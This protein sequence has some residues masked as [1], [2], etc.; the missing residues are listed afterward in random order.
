MKYLY[1]TLMSGIAATLLL[2]SCSTSDGGSSC[3][4]VS[5]DLEGTWVSGCVSTSSVESR[6][7]QVTFSGDRVTV[8]RTDYSDDVC[9]SMPAFVSPLS[10]TFTTGCAVTTTSGMSAYALDVVADAN[11]F[12]Y[13]DI[14]KIEGDTMY[15]SGNI[16]TASRPQSLDF[17][18]IYTRQP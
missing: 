2:T 15:L 18:T 10:G 6:I 3:N 8:S 7:V 12:T 9:G 14:V 5:L 1:K 11:G 13:M 17:D 16:N 4:S